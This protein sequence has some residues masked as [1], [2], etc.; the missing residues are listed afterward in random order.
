MAPFRLLKNI[1][2]GRIANMARDN[3]PRIR[4]AHKFARKS[5]KRDSADRILIV[6]EGSK[7]EPQYF[8]EIRKELRLPTANINVMHSDY[9]TCPR[10]IVEY[11]FDLFTNGDNSKGILPKS[12]EKV[13]AVFDRD[14]HIHYNDALTLAQ[15][16]QG[17]NLR[18]DQR[19]AIEFKAIVS[20]PSFEL[21]LLLH[22]ENCVAPIHRDDV[23]D[24]LKNYI[25]NYE[26]GKEGL[27]KLTK[28]YYDIAK[29]RAENINFNTTA[30]DGTESYTEIYLLIEKLR[31]LKQNRD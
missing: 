29:P 26:K 24:H 22:Y 5:G 20:V 6:T 7:T 10:R 15:S 19:L 11:A 28:D 8:N 2:L 1:K 18:N 27:Y 13:Y 31:N 14:D 12:F 16:L 23:I 21:W 9:G 30:W 3:H 4:Q 17:K 25:P